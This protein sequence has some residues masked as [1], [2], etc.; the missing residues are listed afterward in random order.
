MKMLALHTLAHLAVV[1][2]CR[3]NLGWQRQSVVETTA[4]GIKGTIPASW[5]GMTSLQRL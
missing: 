4:T 2:L 3:R 5:A 1:V